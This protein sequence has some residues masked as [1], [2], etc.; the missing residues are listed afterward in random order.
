VRRR[1]HMAFALGVWLTLA[2]DPNLPNSP[3]TQDAESGNPQLHQPRQSEEFN[4]LTGLDNTP[5]GGTLPGGTLP[6]GTLPGGTL[7][8]GTLPG[9]TVP[10]GTVPG[11][12]LPG[13]PL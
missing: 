11:G 10:G 5:E 3:P 2:M 4:P 12:T 6:G 13:G 1:M 9:G 7:P 8:G